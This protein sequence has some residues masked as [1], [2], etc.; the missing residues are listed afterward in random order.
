M[1]TF[2]K[3][4]RMKDRLR[5]LDLH[6]LEYVILAKSLLISNFCLDENNIC[7]IAYWAAHFQN[8]STVWESGREI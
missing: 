8:F 2:I 3:A 4:H 7:H 1:S 6:I 5:R